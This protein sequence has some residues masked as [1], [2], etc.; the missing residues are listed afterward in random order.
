MAKYNI[1]RISSGIPGFDEIIEG[2]IQ[3]NTTLLVRGGTGTGKTIFGL[4]YLHNG[5]T[6]HDEPGLFIS[7]AEGKQA[8]YQHGSVFSWNFEE[9]EKKGKF[10]FIKYAPHEVVKVMEEGGGS[11]RDTIESIGAKRLVIDSLTAYALLFESEYRSNESILNLFEMLR[12]WKCTTVVT[13]EKQVDPND[14]DGERL[15]FLTDAIAYLY[16]LRTGV[17]RTR[18]M[19]IIKMRDTNH[20]NKICSFDIT[21]KGIMVKPHAKIPSFK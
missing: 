21:K 8:T 11:I 10:T 3:K 16:Y 6:E 14:G 17:A 7:F 15:G 5:A 12:N 2:G 20:S 18:A 19:E 9:L 4:Q 1:E 13:S